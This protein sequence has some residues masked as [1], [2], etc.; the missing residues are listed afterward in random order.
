MPKLQ[1]TRVIGFE[2]SGEFREIYVHVIVNKATLSQAN[3][4]GKICR[5][6]GAETSG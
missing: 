1:L 2:K 4:I 5:L 6:E 3:R